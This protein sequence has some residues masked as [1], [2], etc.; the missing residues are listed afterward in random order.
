MTLFN[1]L[2]IVL[3][4]IN[5]AALDAKEELFLVIGST[6]AD[7]TAENV[8]SNLI[9]TNE[10]TDCT[11][12][13]TWNG[14]ATTF[15]MEPCEN[16]CG[17]HI[18]GDATTFDFSP[19]R[20]KSV[21]LERM[22][23]GS[24]SINE[25][26]NLIGAILKN[27][28][29]HLKPGALLEMELDPFL[30]FQA[31]ATL[32]D[33]EVDL[34]ECRKENPFSGWYNYTLAY[35]A[36]TEAANLNFSEDNLRAKLSAL[37]D[38]DTEEMLKHIIENRTR[39]LV[40][41]EKIATITSISVDTLKLRIHQEMDIYHKLREINRH[42]PQSIGLVALFAGGAALSCEAFTE[43]VEHRQFLT[44]SRA[45]APYF[46]R[47]AKRLN[48]KN[49]HERTFYFYEINEFFSHC[50]S[51]IVLGFMAIEH[52]QAYI[53]DYLENLGFSDVKIEFGDSPYN[54]RKNYWMVSARA[55]N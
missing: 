27:L 4:S 49:G 5:V 3:F 19:Y 16:N 52:N 1:I 12:R 53:V 7:S 48:D 23:T 2:V 35:Y 28:K 18:Q 39:V 33:A 30:G 26:G 45:Q 31:Y 42:T 17:P 54:G 21:F 44:S 43:S 20:I 11:H 13:H 29:P 51:N 55:K 37:T 46:L 36:L 6:R 22:D 25:A 41:L 32:S 14:K 15:D 9:H 8:L 24:A 47:L 34:D 40:W 10:F 38:G 50:L